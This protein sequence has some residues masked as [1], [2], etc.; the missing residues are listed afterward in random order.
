MRPHPRSPQPRRGL[1][2]RPSQP[3]ASPARSCLTGY[4]NHSL[5]VFY[6]KDFQDPVQ[7]EGSENVTECRCGP[8]P[9]SWAPTPDTPDT[10]DPWPH[11]RYRD[12]RDARD[13]SLSEQFWVL[14]AIR[15]LFLILFEV[16]GL[17]RGWG[18]RV[19]ALASSLASAGDPG[20]PNRPLP[21]PPACGLVH[22]AHRCLV[23]A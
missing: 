16:G 13:Y 21:L 8:C 10:P 12:Y 4:V 9:P 7:A 18:G 19:V 15:L 6:T 3:G 20:P 5:S 23:R 11:P 14:L 17:R 1:G 22:Q 2:L